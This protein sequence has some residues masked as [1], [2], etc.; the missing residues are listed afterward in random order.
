MTLGVAEES[1]GNKHSI[2]KAMR[3]VIFIT[4]VVSIVDRGKRTR[5]NIENVWA[6]V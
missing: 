1:I 4:N 2:T 6:I 5:T 3:G